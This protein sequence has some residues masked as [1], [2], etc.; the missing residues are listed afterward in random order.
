MNYLMRGT[1]L[2]RQADGSYNRLIFRGERPES[3]KLD[4]F[5]VVREVSGLDNSLAQNV[6]K[7]KFP[8]IRFW[9]DEERIMTLKLDPGASAAQLQQAL[10][11]LLPPGF[12]I[13]LGT[14]ELGLSGLL[15]QDKIKFLNGQLHVHFEKSFAKEAGW[16]EDDNASDVSLV[17]NIDVSTLVQNK[18]P[19]AVGQLYQ[20]LF[21]AFMDKKTRN[22]LR[23]V[24]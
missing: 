22:T 19:K 7:A 14:H 21:G 13:R 10:S 9:G 4:D 15:L 12:H 16:E 1:Q 20:E 5:H 8:S 11:G 18:S 2:G 24:R 3:P 17:V 6:F 23:S